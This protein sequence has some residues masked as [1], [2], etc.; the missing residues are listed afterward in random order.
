MHDQRSAACWA[1]HHQAGERETWRRCV[2]GGLSTS[3]AP[4]RA[5]GDTR[6]N[7]FYVVS[8]G[9]LDIL[10][11]G[12]KKAEAV[13][14]G[15][16]PGS[17][18][19]VH[20][21]GELALLFD[22]PRAATVKAATHAE[23]WKLDRLTFK[24]IL[25]T[26]SQGDITRIK[27]A[28]SH[29]RSPLASLTPVQLDRVAEVAMLQTYKKGDQI[30]KK[31]DMGD[32][33]YYI[34]HGS[35]L[36]TNIDGQSNNVL[37]AGDY[38]GEQ[39]LI[40]NVPRKADVLAETDEVHLIAIHRE[41]FNLLLGDLGDLL[42]QNHRMRQLLCVPAM[43]HLSEADR[44]RI[45]NAVQLVEFE[46]G[47]VVCDAGDH[48]SGFHIIS[49]GSVAVMNPDSGSE[50]AVLRAVTGVGLPQLMAN[51]PA[52]KHYVAK[53]KAL[54]FFIGKE[55]FDAFLRPV[56]ANLAPAA[57]AR[58]ATGAGTAAPSAGQ[59]S[60]LDA[61]ASHLRDIPFSRL[62][63]GKTLGMGTF[64]RVKLVV[65]KADG[66]AYALKMLQKAQ[67]VAMKQ[68]KN[69]MLEKDILMALNHPF[70]LKMFATYKDKNRLY[71]LMELVQGGELFT[72]LQ[73]Q[74]GAVSVSA[75]RFYGSCVLDALHYL[76]DRNIVYRDLKPE[77]LLVDST[78]HVKVVDFGF[79]KFVKSRTYTLCGTPEYLAP[80]L[81]LL[82]GHNK[83]VD[84]WALGV[85]LY[86]MA[87]GYSPFADHESGSQKAIFRNIVY[88][89]VDFPKALQR[90]D[91]LVQV[92][93]ALLTK[94]KSKRLGSLKGGAEDI[95]AHAFFRR[96]NPAAWERLRS[97]REKTPW[98][99][100][101]KSATDTSNFDPYDEEEDVE[102]YRDDG[103]G[104]DKDF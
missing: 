56:A 78:G 24:S 38:V 75:T 26:T 99:P 84:Y 6:G 28:L 22:S 47:D 79:A 88:N 60:A 46:S 80:E 36:C 104:W 33:F 76:H 65:D 41:D 44:T 73:S 63:I 45:L 12:D 4:L 62:R 90:E 31:G 39:A 83:A 40:E 23:L 74:G 37:C 61:P 82:K 21:F 98:I 85:L 86:E 54:C 52:G 8:S 30:I 3:A 87:V 66:E 77:N 95:K 34:E 53:G 50:E 102:P 92:I 43:A 1:E 67:I 100:P 5:Q 68:K 9:C 101:L 93:R 20:S 14:P 71:M 11:G 10:V 94:D 97:M 69:V 2:F 42:K 27:T 103:T 13:P 89:T 64:G 15:T 72:R 55:E 59:G 48:F 25:M 91:E 96:P 35:V 49:E 19:A 70:V 81:V 58:P 29:E 32:V 57:A 18:P 16:A 7:Y 51:S 17:F